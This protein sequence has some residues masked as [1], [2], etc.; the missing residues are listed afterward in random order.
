MQ[1]VRGGSLLLLAS[2][3]FT[4]SLSSCFVDPSI[5][6][7]SSSRFPS[8][9][10]RHWCRY[11]LFLSLSLSFSWG[12]GIVA[13]ADE[14]A[15]G[16]PKRSGSAVHRYQRRAR[17]RA[18]NFELVR[19][20]TAYVCLECGT[21]CARSPVYESGVGLRRSSSRRP[22]VPARK[23]SSSERRVVALTRRCND[24]DS[25]RLSTL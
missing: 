22:R 25:R 10:H 11:S 2:L 14:D 3:F 20:A 18:V 12:A 17:S 7:D 5:R 9:A 23:L 1:L 4:V 16:E 6:L 15:R 8:I 21:K 24:A 19:D 13:Q